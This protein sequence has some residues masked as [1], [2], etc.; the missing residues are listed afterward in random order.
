MTA[1]ARGLSKAM[2]AE[3]ALY[4]AT[5]EVSA[6]VAMMAE[7]RDWASAMGLAPTAEAIGLWA[8][9]APMDL[10]LLLVAPLAVSVNLAP[11][12]ASDARRT[13]PGCSPSGLQLAVS[14]RGLASGFH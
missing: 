14:D 2:R 1:L 12:Q 5:V 10:A 8:A 13:H 9:E 6:L 3:A 4:A 11:R 7:V